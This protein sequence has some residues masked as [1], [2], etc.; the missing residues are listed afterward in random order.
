MYS[1]SKNVSSQN[2][3][4]KYHTLQGRCSDLGDVEAKLQAYQT[5][6][7]ELL[8]AGRYEH[9]GKPS[10]FK[11]LIMQHLCTQVCVVF[12]IVILC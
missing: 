6:A 12:H 9:R 10:D 7:E 5:F 3:E 4:E 11:G 1:P 2:L 8:E